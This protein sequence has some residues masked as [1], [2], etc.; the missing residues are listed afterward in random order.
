[1][2]LKWNLLFQNAWMGTLEWTVVVSVI[3]ETLLC[4]VNPQGNAQA[5]SA[6]LDGWAQTVLK[7][8]TMVW[9]VSTLYQALGQRQ[10]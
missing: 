2:A 1:M 6:P 7:V 8:V 3:A 5:R 9:F 4:V 10:E